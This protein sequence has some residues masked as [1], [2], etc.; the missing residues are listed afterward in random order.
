MLET[1]HNSYSTNFIDCRTGY[2]FIFASQKKISFW[3]YVTWFTLNLNHVWNLENGVT[4]FFNN[5]KLSF[6]KYSFVVDP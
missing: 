1:L 2:K 6:F 4:L 5:L 3:R